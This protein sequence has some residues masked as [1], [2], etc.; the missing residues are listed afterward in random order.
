ML[1]SQLDTGM[2]QSP[3]IVLSL[4]LIPKLSGLSSISSIP[5]TIKA[6]ENIFHELGHAMH[7]FLGQT[8]HQHVS[9]ENYRFIT[10][11]L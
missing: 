6:A 9:G 2:W 1:L 11:D 4:N 8:I 3:V 10:V 7:S 5:I